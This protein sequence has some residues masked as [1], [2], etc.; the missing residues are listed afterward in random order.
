MMR[1]KVFTELGNVQRPN[2]GEL[3]PDS[4]E[5]LN[6]LGKLQQE[7]RTLLVRPQHLLSERQLM[8]S[9]KT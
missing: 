8:K 6:K 1:G 3:A 5:I 9:T 4:R 7:M 2:L